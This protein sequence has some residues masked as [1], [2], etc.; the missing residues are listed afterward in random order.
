MSGKMIL[1]CSLNVGAENKKG[2][3]RKG[4]FTETPGLRGKGQGLCFLLETFTFSPRRK[5]KLQFQGRSSGL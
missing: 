3:M 5:A 1:F 4:F 2:V